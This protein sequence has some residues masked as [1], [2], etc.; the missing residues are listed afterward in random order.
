MNAEVLI[1]DFFDQ[2]DECAAD[3]IFDFINALERK[4]RGTKGKKISEENLQKLLSRV[5]VLLADREIKFAPQQIGILLNSFAG[6]GYKKEDLQLLNLPELVKI[7][8]KQIDNFS[9]QD[10][11]YKMFLMFVMALLGL[12]MT[13]TNCHLMF[14]V[15]RE[16]LIEKLTILEI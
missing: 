9:A 7:T 10:V 13:K 15:Y 5:N 6:L 16:L 3:K 8:N 2:V 1:A 14:L 4:E 11:S 12:L